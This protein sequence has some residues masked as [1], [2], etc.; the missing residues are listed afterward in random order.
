MQDRFAGR[1][2]ALATIGLAA[3]IGCSDSSGTGTTGPEPTPGPVG[4][5][6]VGNDFFESSHNSSRPANDTVAVGQTVTWTWT[7]TGSVSHSVRSEGTPSF[8]SSDIKAGNGMT[9]TMTFTAPGTYHY[10]CAVHGAAMS[11][12]VV[13]Q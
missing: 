6:R 12:T 8:T 7:S 2:A 5:V 1:L 3:V 11:G 9:Y 10:D 4:S 13:V